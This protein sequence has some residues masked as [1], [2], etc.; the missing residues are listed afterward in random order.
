MLAKTKSYALNG[1]EGYEVSIEV[2]L[3]AGLPGYD[4]VGLAD[5]AIKESKERVRSAIKNSRFTYPIRKITINLAP[6]DTKKEGSHFDLAIALGIM[7][8][9]E[10]IVSKTYKD[11]I[12][13][14][15]LSLDGSINHVKGVMPLVISAVQNG[16]KKFILPAKNAKEASYISGIEVYAFDKLTEVVDFLTGESQLKPLETSE[17]VS[18]Q[19]ANKYNVDFSEGKGQFMAKRAIE[20]AV[21]G[22]HNVLMIGP[23][24]AGKTMMA[25]C[26]PTIM[27]DMT[28]EEAIEVTKIHSVAGILDSS[29]GIVVSR[30][31][32]TPHHTATIPA[33]MGGG[34]NARPGEISLAHNGVL[35]L[36][37]MP[38]YQ[39]RTLETL[40]QPLEDGVAVVSRAKHTLEYP[41]RFMLVASMNPCPCGNL[42]SKTQECKCAPSEIHRYISKLSGPLLDRIDLQIEVDNISY[43]DFRSAV[44][45]ESSKDIKERVEKAR[46][47]QRERYAGTSTNT[48]DEMTNAQVREYCKLDNES[49]ALLKNAFTKLNLTARASSRVLKVSRTIAD[50][51]GSENIL[52]RHVSEAIQYRSLDRKYWD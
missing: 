11:F 45:N 24:G 48:N 3:N 26:V 49:E 14:G 20:I 28:F 52:A 46:R 6:A 8:A 39:R 34:S 1:V 23:P 30:P 32:R 15:E 42:G 43:E 12:I 29:V 47:I 41:A 38:E 16:H 5:T 18:A 4:T 31:F 33:L 2:D 27:P 37:E 40:R 9:N 22:G 13:L 17:F 44:P 10:E 36:D 25:K 50:L 51:D 19:N 35:F 21:A 7:I